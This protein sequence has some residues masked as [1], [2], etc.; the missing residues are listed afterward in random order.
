MPDD[1]LSQKADRALIAVALST[2]AL[3]ILLLALL[4]R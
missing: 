3:L 4:Y 2:V 1:D